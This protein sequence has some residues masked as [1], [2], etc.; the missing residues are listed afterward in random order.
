[1]AAKQD[2]RH[3]QSKGAGWRRL[4]FLLM[5]LSIGLVVL[6]YVATIVTMLWL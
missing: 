3:P 6:A 5:L 4:G 2:K 1:M